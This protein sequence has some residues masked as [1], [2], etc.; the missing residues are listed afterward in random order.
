MII[1]SFDLQWPAEKEYKNQGQSKVNGITTIT[2][3]TEV[4]RD[5]EKNRK[6]ST[7]DILAISVH[8]GYYRDIFRE[9][10]L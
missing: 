5:H 3:G 1:L 6:L 10:F 9:G 2:S 7:S 4:I 8:S